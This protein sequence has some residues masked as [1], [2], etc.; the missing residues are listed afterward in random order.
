MG[1][2]PAELARSTPADQSLGNM[3]RPGELCS[4]ESHFI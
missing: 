3:K 1:E 2:P 4:V